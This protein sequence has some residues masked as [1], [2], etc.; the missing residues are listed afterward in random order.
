M[1]FWC[2]VT[3]F[4]LAS[5]A[6]AGAQFVAPGAA[7]PA[8]ANNP[9][10]NET[11]WRSDVSILNL[12]ATDVSVMLVLYPEIKNSG[13]VFDIQES[14]P[15]TLGG[16]QQITLTNVVDSEFGIRNKKG[17]LYVYSREGSPIVV[18]SRTYTPA[19]IPPGGSYGLNVYGVLVADEAWIGGLEN[20]GFFRTSIGVFLPLGPA[21]PSPQHPMVACRAVNLRV[22]HIF[23]LNIRV[24]LP[25][26]REM[27]S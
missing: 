10:A 26:W 21:C 13:P 24:G 5:V 7:I 8:V 2:L 11:F 20:D 23:C 19:P 4:I 12:E 22:W 1:R 9:G 17:S 25:I 18:S 6:P 14:G 3:I 15:I 16:N 27:Q